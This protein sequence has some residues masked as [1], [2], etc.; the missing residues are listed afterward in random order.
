MGRY[1]IAALAVLLVSG[2]AEAQDQSN[3]TDMETANKDEPRRYETDARITAN[4]R[5]INYKVIAGETFLEK[6][7]R[8]RSRLD[9]FNVIYCRRLC[10][11]RERPVA[12]IFNGAQVRLPCGCIWV[13]LG[14]SGYAYL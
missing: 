3:E 14:Q 8:R 10:R 12:F 1:V 9:L 4:G 2:C 7:E 5:S 13:F 11:P 6:R